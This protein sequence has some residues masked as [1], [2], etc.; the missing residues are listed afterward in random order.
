M[1]NCQPQPDGRFDAVREIAAAAPRMARFIRDARIL[2]AD[3]AAT[4]GLALAGAPPTLHLRI[5]TL[6]D[7][8]RFA[9]AINEDLARAV[10]A[11]LTLKAP[12]RFHATDVLAGQD[13]GILGAT[14]PLAFTVPAAHAVCFELRPQTSP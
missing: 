10:S 2:S 11:R 8:T 1:R 6:P 14:H 13:G 7:G 4:T 5:R 3:G 12:A 9:L